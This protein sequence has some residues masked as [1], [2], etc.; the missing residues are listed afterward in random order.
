MA[1]FNRPHSYKIGSHQICEV[2]QYCVSK[3]VPYLSCGSNDRCTVF[4]LDAVVKALQEEVSHAQ[5]SVLL[6]VVEWIRP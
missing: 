1:T 6:Q 2:S 4:M 5:Q 3:T